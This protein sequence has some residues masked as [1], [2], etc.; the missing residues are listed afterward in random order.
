MARDCEQHGD[1]TCRFES[2]V[3]EVALNAS[4]A[5]TIFRVVQEALTNVRRHAAASRVIVSLHREPDWL[6]VA[7]RDDGRGIGTEAAEGASSL[8]LLG[9]RE[10]AALIGGTIEVRG[11]AGAGTVLTLR[12][13][14]PPA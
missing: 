8:G 12:V 10:R 5:T 11:T 14:D 7:V 3:A 1:L 9:M 13:P 6:V 4:R 2:S